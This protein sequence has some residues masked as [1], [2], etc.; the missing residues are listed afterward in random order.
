MA[1]PMRRRAIRR[2]GLPR[3]LRGLSRLLTIGRGGIGMGTMRMRGRR[4]DGL[5]V[6]TYEAVPGIPP[7]SAM[8]MGRGSSGGMPPGAHSHD[9]LVLTYFERD[10][11]SMWSGDRE[12]RIEA[13][14]RFPSP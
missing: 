14:G 1:P 8:R 7:V 2:S 3:P 5:P 10:G 11:G 13:G 6:Y 9:F 4:D 12:W